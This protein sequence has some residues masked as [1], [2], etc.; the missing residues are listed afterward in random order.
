MWVL[1]HVDGEDRSCKSNGVSSRTGV[2][3]HG[4]SEE[5]GKGHHKRGQT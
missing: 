5:E 3:R 2:I 4:R 1:Q